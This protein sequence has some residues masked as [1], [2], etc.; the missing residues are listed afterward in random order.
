MAAMIRK[1]IQNYSLFI[2]QDK[3]KLYDNLSNFII[4]EISH[5]LK[6]KSRFQFC[7]SGG[8]TPRGVYQLLTKNNLDWSKVDI[9]LGDERCV[10]PNSEDSNSLMIKNSLLREFG[11]KAFFYEIFKDGELNEEISRNLFLKNLQEKCE[12]NPPSFDLT[13]LGLGD[14]GHTASL[15][16]FKKNYSDEDLIIFSYGK[17]LK[18]I[19]LTPKIISA[20]KK[21]IFLVSGS[22]KQLALKRLIDENENPERTP[23]RLISSTKKIYIFCD[24]DASNSLSI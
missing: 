23:A 5:T 4:N 18:R 21:I 17:G 15:F 2:S 12:G 11:S 13:L 8:S 7:V 14:D 10:D 22:P 16:P 20:S 9:F 19:S 6:N 3:E 24:N 1:D